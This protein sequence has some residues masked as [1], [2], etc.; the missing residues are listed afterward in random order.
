MIVLQTHDVASVARLQRNRAV[1]RRQPRAELHGLGHR[2]AGQLDAADPGRESE[3]VLDPAGRAG[4]AAKA[5]AVDHER[6]KPFGGSVDSGAQ[7]RR[8]GTDHEQVDLLPGRE[9]AADS[10]RARDLTR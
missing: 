10:K 7:T 8:A 3:V 6:V 5:R 2:A 9:L 4:L 1:G